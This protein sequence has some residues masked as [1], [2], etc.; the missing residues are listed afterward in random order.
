MTLMTPLGVIYNSLPDLKEKHYNVLVVIFSRVQT[1]PCLSLSCLSPSC[2][3]RAFLLCHYFSLCFYSLFNVCFSFRTSTFFLWICV[4]VGRKNIVML[5]FLMCVC[6]SLGSLGCSISKSLFV[7]LLNVIACTLCVFPR[8]WCQCNGLL[9]LHLCSIHLSRKM[10]F[11]IAYTL[12]TSLGRQH[13]PLPMLC[14][15]L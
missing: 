3:F 1:S 8:R 13:V 11:I 2:S 5:F 6:P 12:C 4:H 9:S 7:P 15:P 14:V 10:M